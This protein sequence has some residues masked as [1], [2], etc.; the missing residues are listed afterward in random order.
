M[1]RAFAYLVLCLVTFRP[2]VATAQ[3]FETVGIRAQG[4]GG[5]FVALADDA[6][7]TWWNPAGLAAG[8]YFNALIEYDRPRTPPDSSVKGIAVA[9]PSLGLSY[10]RLPIN[11]MRPA[12]STGET[13]ERRQDQGV[14]SVYGATVGQS[15][16][17]HLV[18]ASTL[19][20]LRAGDTQGDL[21]VGAM[22]KIGAARVGLTVK[23]VRKPTIETDGD[24]LT[25][26]RQA[27]AGVALGASPGTRVAS[28]A[29]ALDADLRTVHTWAG[30]ARRV[31]GGVEAWVG[32]RALGIRGGVG[33]NTI[34]A[35]QSTYSGGFSVAFRA[36]T[37]VDGQLTKGSD[38]SRRGWGL[39]LRMTF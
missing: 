39:A 10:Y 27:R 30:D 6:T 24:P 9:M 31:A 3:S 2:L 14:L 20:L 26:E 4:M 32:Q 37:Y 34:G 36:G 15:L 21:D 33:R 29:V 13:A 5:A 8:A 1:A 19:K 28:I 25:L 35:K 18:V 16:G 38:E 12:A 11:Q 17:T 23:N 7:A 22:A